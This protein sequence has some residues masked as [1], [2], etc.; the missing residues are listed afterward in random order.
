[1]A[2]GGAP[3][4]VEGATAGGPG[5]GTAPGGGGDQAATRGGGMMG[6]GMMGG[7]GAAGGGGG[8][9]S[10]SSNAAYRV[11]ATDLFE[12][13]VGEGPFGVARISGSLDDEEG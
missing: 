5:V 7:A 3:A 12:P 11:S 1:M 4:G 13:E 6:G 2:G 9:E 8:D 10:R